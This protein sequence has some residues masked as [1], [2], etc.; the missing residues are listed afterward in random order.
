MNAQDS[1]DVYL[2][3]RVRDALARDPRV[4]ELGLCVR[5]VCGKLFLSGAVASEERRRAVADVVADAFPELEIH[6]GLRVPAL[7]APDVETMR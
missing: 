6:N 4:G 1:P 7:A 3:Q 5:L 2:E